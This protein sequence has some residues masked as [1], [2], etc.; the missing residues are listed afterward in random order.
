MVKISG[1]KWDKFHTNTLFMIY[2]ISIMYIAAT[3]TKYNYIQLVFLKTNFNVY[4][5]FVYAGKG[6]CRKTI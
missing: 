5:A 4:A 6:L 3:A 2:D 1:K